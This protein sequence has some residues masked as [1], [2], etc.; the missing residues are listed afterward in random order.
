M[1]KKNYLKPNT[2]YRELIGDCI[3][4]VQSPIE[5]RT[6]DEVVRGDVVPD[7]GDPNDFAAKKNNFSSIWDE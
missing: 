4:L 2:K 7:E 3:L 6:T 5:Q 1:R